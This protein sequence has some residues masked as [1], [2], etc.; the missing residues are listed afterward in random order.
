M[1]KFV[2][3]SLEYFLKN[4]QHKK[5]IAFGTGRKFIKFVN[6]FNIQNDIVFAIDNDEN[7]I[8]TTIVINNKTITIQSIEYLKDNVE[9]DMII[10][11]TNI[12]SFVHIFC[13]INSYMEFENVECYCASLMQDKCNSEKIIYTEGP[14][15][16]PKIIHYCWFGKTNFPTELQKYIDSWKVICP[17]YEIIRWDESNYDIKKCKYVEEA[18]EN[19]LWAFV[20][21]YA[22]LD[23]VYEYGGIYVDTD[24][25]CV[26]RFDD[27][28]CDDAFF[29]FANYNEI[30]TGLAFGARKNN[31]LIGRLRDAYH[32]KR[33]VNDDG[34]FNTTSCIHYQQPIFQEYGFELNNKYQKINN[35]VVYPQEVFSP[36]GSTT[37]FDNRTRNTHSIHHATR[38]WETKRNSND[39]LESKALFQTIKK[40]CVEV[41]ES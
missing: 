9:E 38:T 33:I 26:K 20:S 13:Q 21:D 14:Q 40:Y 11:I 7:K 19:K 12:A 10:I 17:D 23:V 31:E 35:C 41:Y 28:L 18:Y 30:A 32:D 16:I 22:R 39:Y 29:G 5:L 24:V 34:T 4:K 3:C 25:E 37:F 6:D 36:L 27:L 1:A 8:G 15:I 2:N